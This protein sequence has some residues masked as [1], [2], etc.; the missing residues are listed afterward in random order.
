MCRRKISTVAHSFLQTHTLNKHDYIAKHYM[1]TQTHVASICAEKVCFTFAESKRTSFSE[2][3]SL[4]LQRLPTFEVSRSL[5]FHR[6]SQVVEVKGKFVARPRRRDLMD[7]GG[8]AGAAAD[9]DSAAEMHSLLSTVKTV[10]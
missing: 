7:G 9:D 5:L 6:V 1:H 4:S 10:Y 3:L 2:T 8:G